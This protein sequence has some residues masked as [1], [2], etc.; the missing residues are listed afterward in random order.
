MKG[1]VNAHKSRYCL[2][3]KA[4]LRLFAITTLII[5]CGTP[6]GMTWAVTQKPEPPLGGLL[7]TPTE[8]RIA[9]EIALIISN[10]VEIDET[11]EQF[12]VSGFVL[13]SWNDSRLAFNLRSDEKV[14]L[15]RQD[16]FGRRDFKCSMQWRQHQGRSQSVCYRADE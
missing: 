16:Q 13:A 2:S 9:V 8:G 5:L 4:L 6:W 7:D 11:R 10:L 1:S 3:R 14:H 12:R 15:Y